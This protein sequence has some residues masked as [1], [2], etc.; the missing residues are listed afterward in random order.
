MVKSG[1][2][3]EVAA[4]PENGQSTV[5]ALR[6]PLRKA[7]QYGP[8]AQSLG[9][10]DEQ[11]LLWARLYYQEIKK[12]VKY[13]SWGYQHNDTKYLKFIESYG[14]A[15]AEFFAELKDVHTHQAIILTVDE[16]LTEAPVSQVQRFNKNCI[17]PNLAESSYPAWDKDTQTTTAGALDSDG[18]YSSR[19]FSGGTTFAE[20]VADA[21]IAGSGVGD[22]SKALLTTDTM[23]QIAFYVK[24]QIVAE[25]IMLDNI[26]TY[27]FLVPSR[28]WHWTVNPNN[29]GSFGSDFQPMSDYKDPD[30]IKLIG[31]I[32]RLYTNFL[33]V[34]DHRAPTI[35]LGGSNGSWTLRPNYCLPGNNDDRNNG[36]WSNVSGATNY[37]YDIGSIHGANSLCE[38]LADQLR[39]DLMESTNYGQDQGRGG[40]LGCGVQIPVFDKDAAG[41]LDGASTTQIQRN[42]IWIPFSRAPIATIV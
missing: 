2:W 29:S 37:V 36:S 14:P 1:I 18:Y 39:T 38:Y 30:R 33:L 23:N 42:C 21:M 27:I 19:V 3:M 41:Q 9:N 17:V 32:G 25:P 7:P 34:E 24:E 15:L 5:V 8:A 20:N 16:S 28:V 35:T 6:T 10:E 12:A 40:Y 13:K 26:P 4:N 31:E 22:T 11:D